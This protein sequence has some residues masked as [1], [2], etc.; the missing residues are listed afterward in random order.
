[1]RGALT[2]APSA[3][4]APAPG[5]ADVI[6]APVPTAVTPLASSSVPSTGAREIGFGLEPTDDAP[7]DGGVVPSGPYNDPLGRILSRYDGDVREFVRFGVTT[8]TYAATPT[9]RAGGLDISLT[10]SAAGDG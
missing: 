8:E 4:V 6:Y 7:A 3:A 9:Q 10:F 5:R 1:M 2:A